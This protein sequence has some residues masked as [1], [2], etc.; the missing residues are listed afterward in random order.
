MPQWV[1]HQAVTE[2]HHAVREVV[3]GQPCHDT[4]LLHVRPARHIDDE[5]AQ[6][7]PVPGGEGQAWVSHATLFPFLGRPVSLPSQPLLG[8]LKRISDQTLTAAAA[9]GSGW[10]AAP[11]RSAMTLVTQSL[12][13]LQQCAWSNKDPTAQV[14]GLSTPH[15]EV[16]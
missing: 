5:V 9:A 10:R 12:C 7:L 8:P 11:W 3:L 13:P 4:L 15:Q 2:G 6:V 14:R 1:V 16:R